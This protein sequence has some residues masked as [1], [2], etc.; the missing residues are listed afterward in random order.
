MTADMIAGIQHLAQHMVRTIKT[1]LD[2]ELDFD[3]A[4]AHTLSA[5]IDQIRP[6]YPDGVPQ[7]LVQTLGAFLGECIRATY[8][9]A[10]A[11]EEGALEWGLAIP[12]QSGHLWAFPFRRVYRHFAQGQAESVAQFFDSL[13]LLTDPRYVWQPAPETAE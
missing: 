10:W 1:E 5:Y 7:G 2:V 12:A 13:K 4:A 9:G 11:Y 8:G 6:R 3:A